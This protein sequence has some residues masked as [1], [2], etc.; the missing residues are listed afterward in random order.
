MNVRPFWRAAEKALGRTR[1]KPRRQPGAGLGATAWRDN[2]VQPRYRLFSGGQR[3][4]PTALHSSRSMYCTDFGL[5]APV[6]I[7]RSR[8]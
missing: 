6:N 4:N 5:F 3:T 8:R 7:P 2:V 1:L